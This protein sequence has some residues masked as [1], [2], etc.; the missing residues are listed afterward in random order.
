M[1]YNKITF[2]LILI[3]LAIP[4]SIGIL[5]YQHHIET[6]NVFYEQQSISVVYYSMNN[7]FTD[8]SVDG[9]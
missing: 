4:I 6:E 8:I 1:K 9:I 5:E 7:I 3:L 2:A